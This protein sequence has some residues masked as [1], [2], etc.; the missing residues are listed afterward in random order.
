MPTDLVSVLLGDLMWDTAIPTSIHFLFDNNYLNLNVHNKYISLIMYSVCTA[1]LSTYPT[2][3]QLSELNIE[4]WFKVGLQLGLTEDQLGCLKDSPQP[5]TATL[6]EAKKE[7][8]DLNWKYVVGS[9]LLVGE[10]KV[11][12]SVCSQQG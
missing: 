5:T 2:A 8:I 1:P 10:Y 12:E 4:Q 7:N 3:K 6:L 11:A 9:L